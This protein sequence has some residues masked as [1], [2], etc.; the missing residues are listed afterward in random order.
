MPGSGFGGGASISDCSVSLVS[1]SSGGGVTEMLSVGA[2]ARYLTT[3][4]TYTFWRSRYQKHTMFALEAI[5][6]PFNTTVTFGN[7][8]QI[9][10]NKTA[11]LIY[12]MYGIIDLPGIKGIRSDRPLGCQQFPA[13]NACDP[14]GDGIAPKDCCSEG[15]CYDKKP[16][17]S[18]KKGRHHYSESESD[19]TMSEWSHEKSECQ[20][21]YSYHPKV[22]CLDCREAACK[23]VGVK[24]PWAH[25]TNAIGQFLIK[26]VGLVIGSQLVDHMT[27]DYLFMWEELAGKP[28]KRLTEMIGKRRTRAELIRDSAK[29]RRYYVPLPFSFTQHPGN[30]LPQVSLHFH[31]I[32]IFM[33]FETLQRSIQVS[34]ADV[35]VVK[36]DNGQPLDNNDLHARIEMTNV[37][38]D[39]VERDMFAVGRFEQLI[40][41][42]QSY[43][44]TFNETFARVHIPFNHPMIELIWAVRRRV[45]EQCNNHFDFSGKWNEDPLKCACL[46]LNN[47]IR[48]APR[49]GRYFRL[50]Q[51]YQHHTL[52]PDSFVYSFS[53]A[54]YPE[55]PSPSGQCNFSRV[56]S[57]E[58]ILEFQDEL[59]REEKTVILFGRNWNVYK[60]RRGVGGLG[61]LS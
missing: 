13:C 3:N 29:N 50:V 51:P 39:V 41:Q 18:D 33:A 42:V 9:T 48:M 31:G 22:D 14:A 16:C 59:A 34:C 32:Q 26:K 20:S 5:E 10:L 23:C 57:I 7:E 47:T 61:F 11:D 44:G 4:A 17:C 53:F 8:V 46:K 56:D 24:D 2:M 35:S 38:L 54:L 1:A 6:Q 36:C 43:Y 15:C 28:G 37:Y 25:W 12:Y 21:E 27:N 30:A 55:S 49:E 52:I 60:I 45:N 40:T 19:E 58:L